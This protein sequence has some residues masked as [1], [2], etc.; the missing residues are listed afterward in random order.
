MKVQVVYPTDNWI[1]EKWGEYLVN[2]ID[3]VTGSHWNSSDKIRWD[4]TYFVNYALYKPCNSKIVGGYFTHE[5]NKRFKEIAKKMDFVVCMC[6]KYRRVIENIN[7]NNYIIHQPTDLKNFKPKIRLGFA[8]RF[9]KS[10]RKGEDLLNIVSE[11]PFVDIK[12]ATGQI[13]AKD[14]GDF[15]NSIDYILI[16]SKLE[17]GPM[18][19]T[20]GLACGKEI[21][22]SNVGLVPELKDCGYVYV[23]DRSDPQ[24]LIDLLNDLYKKRLQIRKSVKDFSIKNFVDKHKKLFEEIIKW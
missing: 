6:E 13:K 1:L 2:G 3:F 10:G 9:Y 12:L 4:L 17:G 15:Y 16:T 19:L 21:I 5:E 23:Y 14:M 18:C 22:T 24:N 7:K 8:S 11:L 20:E